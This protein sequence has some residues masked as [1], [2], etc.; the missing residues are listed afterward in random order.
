[1]VVSFLHSLKISSISMTSEVSHPVKVRV[2]RLEQPLNKLSMI[3]T[4]LVFQL[5]RSRVLIVEQFWN[6]LFISERELVF[7]AL[8]PVRVKRWVQ[9]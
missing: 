6:M 8:V 1:M 7:Q 3:T 4:S 9:S 2:V 5:V